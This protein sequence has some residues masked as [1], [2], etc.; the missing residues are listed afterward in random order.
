MKAF[1]HQPGSQGTW[2]ADQGECKVYSD[3]GH[4]STGKENSYFSALKRLS[5]CCKCWTKGL[6]SPIFQISS[7]QILSGET[8][9]QLQFAF[10]ISL[11]SPSF[12]NFCQG[13][14]HYI[15]SL[16]NILILSLS[17]NV[18]RKSLFGEFKM[19]NYI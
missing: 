4:K 2:D 3:R 19:E 9:F 1:G 7:F 13:I 16:S 11:F 6:Y 15:Y 5:L 12:K 14:F 17:R 10:M 8:A 18:A